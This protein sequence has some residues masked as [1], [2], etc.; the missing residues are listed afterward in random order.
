MGLGLVFFEARERWLPGV[1]LEFGGFLLYFA[2][3][4]LP[5]GGEV[6]RGG[7]GGFY[8]LG[9]GEWVEVCRNVYFSEF[10]YADRR[11]YGKFY[12]LL[13]AEA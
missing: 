2:S 3:L 9:V 6:F 4:Q 8:F 5:G 10:L 7:V 13:M 11:V 1:V 12:C